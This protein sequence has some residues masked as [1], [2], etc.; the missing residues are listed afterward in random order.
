MIIIY[1]N[2]ISYFKN[3]I[4][5]CINYVFNSQKTTNNGLLNKYVKSDN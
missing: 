4:T 5:N 3:I 1:L 2:N